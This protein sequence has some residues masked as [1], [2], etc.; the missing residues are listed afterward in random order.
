VRSVQ[1]IFGL[2]PL[3][4]DAANQLDLSDLFSVFP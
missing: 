4:A 3:L 2:T 1:E